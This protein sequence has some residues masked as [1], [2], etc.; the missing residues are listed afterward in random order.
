MP[1]Y[2]VINAVIEAVMDMADATGPFSTLRRGA[3]GAE[4]GLVCEIS[5]SGESQLFLDKNRTIN[6]GLTF[7]GKHSNLKTL[8]E[9]MNK[10]HADL[11]RAT[12][13]PEDEHVPPKWEIWDITNNTLPQIIGR[14]E[15]NDWLMA[16]SLTVKFYWKG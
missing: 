16:S 12:S 9:A 1:E 3:L 6:L 13:Y 11:T 15:N 10:I 7:N 4:A 8:S 5:P 2:D 14:E